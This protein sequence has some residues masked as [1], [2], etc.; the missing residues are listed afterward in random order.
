[1]LFKDQERAVKEIKIKPGIEDLVKEYWSLTYPQLEDYFDFDR[2]LEQLVIVGLSAVRQIAQ[3]V[4]V[5]PEESSLT[6]QSAF[7][8]L[9]DQDNE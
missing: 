7:D 3:Q 8:G 6:Y 2:A 9:I 4:P 5:I 1:M